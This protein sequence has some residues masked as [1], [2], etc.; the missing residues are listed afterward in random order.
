MTAFRTPRVAMSPPY[1]NV[2]VR[3]VWKLLRLLRQHA[4]PDTGKELYTLGSLDLVRIL[5]L[6]TKRLKRKDCVLL[7][8]KLLTL[9]ARWASLEAGCHT[10]VYHSQVS[11]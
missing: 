1:R 5:E 10:K 11:V 4:V 6:S 9:K 2:S 3:Y 8:D 7:F